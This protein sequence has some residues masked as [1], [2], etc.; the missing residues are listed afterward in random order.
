MTVERKK[1][2]LEV[3]VD[4]TDLAESMTPVERGSK[5]E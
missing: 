3:A 5:T 4:T 1:R 2:I